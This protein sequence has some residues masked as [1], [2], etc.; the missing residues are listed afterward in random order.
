MWSRRNCKIKWDL[1]CDHDFL[2]FH[3]FHVCTNSV[4]C[5]A[6]PSPHSAKSPRGGV[7]L[8]DGS[9]FFRCEGEI[10]LWTPMNL[11]VLIC[12]FFSFSLA[13][14]C[15][16]CLSESWFG[17]NCVDKSKCSSVSLTLLVYLSPWLVLIWKRSTKNDLRLQSLNWFFDL[18]IK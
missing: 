5:S 1:F 3:F 11:R 13:V 10:G 12:T 9:S 16:H 7:V 8:L 6:L 17:N 2:P 4:F 15:S 14:C 18:R